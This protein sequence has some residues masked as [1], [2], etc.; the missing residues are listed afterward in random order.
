M[1]DVIS[2]TREPGHPQTV[3]GSRL[4][5]SARDLAVAASI[6]FSILLIQVVW[7]L[8]LLDR[9]LV[10][11]ADYASNS[12]LVNDAKSFALLHGNYSRANFYHPGPAILYFQ[13]FGEG[14]VFDVLRAARSPFGGQAIGLFIYTA[15]LLCL[16]AHCMKL[17][18]GGWNPALM[19]FAWLLMLIILSYPHNLA[20][21]WYPNLYTTPFL[22]FILAS[23]CLHQGK[24]D[25]LPSF[26]VASVILVHGH[27]S[28]A[29]FV[30]VGALAAMIYLT[31]RSRAAG[32]S[33]FEV[34]ATHRLPIGVA[35]VIAMLGVVP[36]ALHTI[37]H[38]PGEF[39]HYLAYRPDVANHTWSDAI[40]FI[41]VFWT[42]PTTYGS[43]VDDVPL[44]SALVAC[45][46]TLLLG[47]GRSDGPID[48]SGIHVSTA[49]VFGVVTLLVL[50]YA[51][52]RVDDLRH[53]YTI[54]FYSSAIALVIAVA[55]GRVVLGFLGQSNRCALPTVLM[56]GL[57]ALS[58]P[59]LDVLAT[60]RARI[61][62]LIDQAIAAASGES[63]R[64][65]ADMSDEGAVPTWIYLTAVLLS[66]E[67][68]G[69][70]NICVSETS[71]R[72]SYH[73]R[74][75]CR[76]ARGG[77]RMFIGLPSNLPQGASI[78]A[79]TDNVILARMR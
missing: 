30:A 79:S 65:E 38:Y 71:W 33:V 37:L 8:P 40:R 27:V 9:D 39:A 77:A 44:I 23:I 34:F 60:D 36:I 69:L 49:I 2:L 24:L 5:A 14:L 53:H 6:F 76:G 43:Q 12:M 64:L 15:F 17:A 11:L 18:I 35:L 74:T 67:R 3:K 50:I 57:C 42:H 16:A 4:S 47:V 29:M 21:A 56:L 13:A 26:A 75:R 63:V 22:L 20:G 31:F 10:E 78:V 55:L 59:Q 45:V 62:S 51:R 32:H 72:L 58:W 1:N 66:T 48:R 19:I 28:F 25:S 70:R 46:L 52:Y 68:A 41:L 73:E 7:N 61:S 54:M